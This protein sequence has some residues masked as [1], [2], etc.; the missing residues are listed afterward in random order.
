MRPQVVTKFARLCL[1]MHRVNRSAPW[2]EQARAGLAPNCSVRK[3]QK[4]VSGCLSLRSTLQSSQSSFAPLSDEIDPLDEIGEHV[5]AELL[6]RVAPGPEPFATDAPRYG[7]LIEDRKHCWRAAGRISRWE[8][9]LVPRYFPA[10][11]HEPR[12]RFGHCAPVR[13]LEQ[14]TPSH[15]RVPQ[16]LGCT[17][18]NACLDSP[19]LILNSLTQD[20]CV[21]DLKPPWVFTPFA[22]KKSMMRALDACDTHVYV[23]PCAAS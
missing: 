19:T 23:P 10:D 14:P 8:V 4:G 22:P 11:N 18:T 20:C 2:K 5:V 13:Q 17:R 7:W 6:G 9:L 3:C 1:C 12:Q 21:W 16:S 15:A